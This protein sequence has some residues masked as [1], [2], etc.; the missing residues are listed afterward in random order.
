MK[1]FLFLLFAFVLPLSAQTNQ[2]LIKENTINVYVD[3]R[4]CDINYLKEKIEYVNFVRDR[5]DADVHILFSSQRTGGG[6]KKVSLFFIGLNKFRNTNDTL[7]YTMKNDDTNDMERVKME[8]VIKLGL[9]KYVAK[10]PVSENIEIRFKKAKSAGEKKE[11]TDEWNFWVFN[12][13][14]D[15]FVNGSENT[16]YYYFYGDVSASRVTEELKLNLRVYGNY[17]EQNFTYNDIVTKSIKRNY[18]FSGAVIKSLTE[19]WSAGMWAR[20]SSS[21]YSNLRLALKLSPGIEYNIFPYSMSN[22]KQLRIGYYLE[23]L[24]NKYFEETIY[25]KTEET[26]LRHS[27]RISVELVQPWGSV[28]MN[29]SWGNYLH[30]FSKYSIDTDLS[31]NLRLIKGLSLRVRG[32]YSKINDQLYLPKRGATKEEVLLQQREL[33]TQ[34]RFWGSIGFSY[35]FGSIYNNIVNPRF[36]DRF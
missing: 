35:T 24:R 23:G 4:G 19:H 6:G 33:E 7:F 26:L 36:G 5:K 13:G 21:A 1:K 12:T 17:N 31:M 15:G 29:V 14:V 22:S 9:M 3:C 11:K 32:G 8:H 18:G 25:F 34:Y 28:D 2:N 30:D 20:I 27:L 10:T 16:N